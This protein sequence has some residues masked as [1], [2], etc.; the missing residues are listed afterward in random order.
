MKKLNLN[1]K[2]NHKITIFSLATLLF[3]YLL[4]LSIPS[5]YNSGRVQKALSEEIMNEFDL[6]ISLSSDISY[7]ILPLPHFVIRDS[8][9]YNFNSKVSKQ[10]GE[11]K[12]LKVYIYQGN[13]FNKEN[14]KIKKLA[15]EKGNFYLKKDDWPF[16]KKYLN[17]ILS[18][19]NISI[20]NSKLFYNDKKNN[21]VLIQAIKD[22]N[23]V[24]LK[25][26]NENSL[27]LN[28]EIFKIPYKLEWSKNFTTEN[29]FLKFNLNK[30]ELDF[31]NK[32]IIKDK[33]KINE[34]I[35]NILNSKFVTNYEIKDD[36]IFFKSDKSR[37]KNTPI[38]FDGTI[39]LKPFYLDLKVNAKKFDLK[40][41]FKNSF[42]LNEIINSK[43]FE[44]E[45]FNGK[46]LINS[47][48]V[49]SNFFN[50]ISL[51]LN[52][53]EGNVNLN[54]SILSDG[55]I[56]TIKIFNSE[57]I[58][59]DG[60]VFVDTTTRLNVDNLNNFYKNF[61]IPKG[62]R[63]KFSFIDF[64]SEFDTLNGDFKIYKISFYDEK[65]KKI[66]LQEID[67]FIEMNIDKKFNY[68]NPIGFKNYFNKL[69]KI[70]Y[71]DG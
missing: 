27:N 49:R 19:K 32:N 31:I 29:K 14:I 9:L 45:N 40:Y 50:D 64:K 26:V 21:P 52:F 58:L 41:F 53:E 4:Y 69:L 11:F 57:F 67:E 6:N 66:N 3:I 17:K 71:L 1:I 24:Y 65:N 30:I 10:L 61:F 63:K 43:F 13:F 18:P 68:V 56:G 33:K 34:N 8:K 20:K 35:I 51:S 15:I 38:S 46:I 59:K 47:D 25:S 39:E 36:I 12:K 70:Y 16:F 42:W 54:N 7:R 23:L 48:K 2:I 44:N 62:K 5:L 28:G 60:K 37:I 22:L 55:K